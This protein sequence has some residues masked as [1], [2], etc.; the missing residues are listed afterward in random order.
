M[1]SNGVFV[2]ALLR[3]VMLWHAWIANADELRLSDIVSAVAAKLG[4]GTRFTVRPHYGS[5]E[6]ILYSHPPRASSLIPR[7]DA[8]LA[9]VRPTDSEGRTYRFDVALSPAKERALN[10][11]VLAVAMRAEG[12][13]E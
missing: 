11:A 9:S 13:A 7:A 8:T 12:G 3:E 6:C 4:P 5:A 2:A 10:E 1:Q